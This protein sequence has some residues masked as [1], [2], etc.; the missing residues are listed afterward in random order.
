MMVNVE[1]IQKSS[2]K[3]LKKKVNKSTHMI[4]LLSHIYEKSKLANISIITRIGR[5]YITYTL[6]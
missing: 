1:I 6:N 4:I 2:F 3:K 5:C